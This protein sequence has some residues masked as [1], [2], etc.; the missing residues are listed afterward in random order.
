MFVQSTTSVAWRCRKQLETQ[1]LME[2]DESL[3]DCFAVMVTVMA[4]WD[5]VADA[6]AQDLQPRFVRLPPRVPVVGPSVTDGLHRL[7]HH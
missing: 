3:L 2:H 5:A 6:V 1:H 7:A 4:V